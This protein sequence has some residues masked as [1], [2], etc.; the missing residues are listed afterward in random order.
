MST[1]TDQKIIELA[2]NSSDPAIRETVDKLIFAIKL[3]YDKE[4][5]INIYD[6]YTHHHGIVVKMPCMYKEGELH[7]FSIAWKKEKFTIISMEHQIIQGSTGDFVSGGKAAEVY[8]PYD[9]MIAVRDD[10]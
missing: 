5:L 3:K 10:K 2:L 4:D 1:L 9:P 7:E 8:M 6:N